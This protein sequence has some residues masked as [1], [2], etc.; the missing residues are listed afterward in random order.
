MVKWVW[1]MKHFL[2]ETK[3][4]NIFCNKWAIF[5]V[6][7]SNFELN[8]I[9]E[10]LI[11][12]INVTYLANIKKFWKLEILQVFTFYVA[13]S[14]VFLKAVLPFIFLYLCVKVITLWNLLAAI[15]QIIKLRNLCDKNKLHSIFYRPLNFCNRH[16]RINLFYFF[17]INISVYY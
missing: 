2:V 9:L 6:K 8:L 17:T 3:N 1:S 11:E 16:Q 10:F 7:R 4:N 5:S 12:V 15:F 13:N 14:F